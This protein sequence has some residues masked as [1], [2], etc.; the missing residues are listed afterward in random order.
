MRNTYTHLSQA[1]EKVADLEEAD[2][3]ILPLPD[4]N[5]TEE[6]VVDDNEF[7]D[8]IPSG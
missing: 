4:G 1:I 8:E 6:E 7:A 3:C 2:I 5:D